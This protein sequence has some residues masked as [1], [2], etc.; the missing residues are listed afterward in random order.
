MKK[1]L[2]FLLL[3]LIAAAWLLACCRKET[4]PEDC[5]PDLPCA[6]QMGVNTFGCYING[7]PWVAALGL[8]VLDPAL[9]KT[10]ALYDETGYGSYHD[11]YWLING[12][13]ID[14]SNN[15]IIWLKMTPIINQGLVETTS[16]TYFKGYVTLKYNNKQS[17]FDIDR[18]QPHSIEITHLDTLQNVC[19]GRFDFFAVTQDKKDTLHLTNG[20]FDLKYVP[21]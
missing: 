7:K 18:E 3:P 13:R 15:D 11:N 20:R 9:R 17:Y 10:Y 21:E 16:L 1:K 19:S 6:T 14:E 4:E 12:N 5:P 8:N 2:F